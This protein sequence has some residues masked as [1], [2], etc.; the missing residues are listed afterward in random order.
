MMAVPV[1]NVSILKIR[2]RRLN[3]KGNGA[4][5]DPNVVTHK[6]TGTGTLTQIRSVTG[7]G[8]LATVHLKMAGRM[9]QKTRLLALLRQFHVSPT[10][11]QQAAQVKQTDKSETVSKSSEDSG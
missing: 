7:T 10:Q 8:T 1:T 9:F 6:I 3:Q 5:T 2:Y 4:G 11:G